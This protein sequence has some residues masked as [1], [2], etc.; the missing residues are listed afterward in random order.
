MKDKIVFI[1]PIRIGIRKSY[2]E[3]V[4]QTIEK[5]Y[6]DILQ[7]GFTKRPAFHIGRVEPRMSLFSRRKLIHLETNRIYM[8]N[9]TL[10]HARRRSKIDSRHD[11]PIE[12]IA[13]FPQR[14][15]K[16]DL[17]YDNKLHTFLYVGEKAKF[18]INPKGRI[19]LQDGRTSPVLRSGIMAL[20]A[21][22]FSVKAWQVV[23]LEPTHTSIS[24]V[25]R[26]DIMALPAV[27]SFTL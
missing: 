21:V 5:V 12:E 26:S 25:L 1:I 16:M 3:I 14:R 18:V 2:S 11:V 23:G 17:Y 22:I 27:S 6:Q 10:S 13:E 19:K 24:P 15:S 9:A 20:P 4:K 8:N 7:L